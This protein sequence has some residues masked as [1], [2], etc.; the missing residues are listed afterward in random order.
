M[1]DNKLN[2]SQ[3]CQ[4][5]TPKYFKKYEFRFVIGCYLPLLNSPAVSCIDI[6]VEPVKYCVSGRTILR[7]TNG[8]F[9]SA[10]L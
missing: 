7:R 3:A 9:S 4:I 5:K 2:N 10:G 8:L 1:I 6:I